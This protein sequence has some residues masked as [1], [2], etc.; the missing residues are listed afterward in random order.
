MSKR[1]SF[2]TAAAVVAL[3]ALAV[4]VRAEAPKKLNLKKG[5]RIVLMGNGL[6]S[7]MI[8]FGHFE[9]GLHLRHPELNLWIRNMC[10][11]GNTPS[12]RPH[13][14]RKYQLGFPGAEKFHAP[15]SDGNTADGVGHFETEEQWIARLKPDVLIAFFGFN[16]SFQGR[17]GIANFQAE[18]DAFLKHTKAQKYNGTSVAQLALVSPTAFEDLSETLDV[19][20]GKKQNGNLAAYTA[21]MK[22]V[23]ADNDVLFIDVFGPSLA[24][25][26]QSPKP[27]TADGALLNND[28]YE[29]FSEAL[30][31]GVFGPSPL[32]AE[33]HRK[34]VH[35]AVME[36]NWF[37]INDFKIPNGVH[38]FGRRYKP[39]G[40][41]NYPY[42]IKKIRE[43]TAHRDE[44][45]WA[46][47]EG[48][49]ID[50]A[51]RDKKTSPLPEVKTNFKP[52]KKNGALEYLKGEAAL[53][54][55][56]VPTGYKIQQFATEQE[57][58]NLQNPVQMSFD[59]KGR[60]WIAVM[61]SYPHYR[62]GDP[63]PDDKLLIY[64]DTNGDGKADKEIVF[65]D[66][67]HLPMG[68]ELAPEGVYVSQGINLVLLRDTDGDD[69]A[70]QKEVILSGFD[71]H[72]T[73]HAIG[74]YCA[75]PSGAF[76][77]CEGVFLRSNIETSR[78]PIRG[79]N[80]GFFRY[81]PQRKRLERHAQLS[82]PNPWGVAF[83]D[84]GQHFF[85]HTSGPT[86]EWM[87]PG[88]VKPRYGAANPKSR[89]LLERAHSVRPTSG[90]EFMSSRHFPDEVQGDL[91]LNNAIGFR[92]TKQHKMTEDGTGYKT[93]W[94]QDL[95]VSTDG[96]YR[97]VDLEIAPDGSLY[98]VDWHN[99]LI[100]H[101]QHNA[102]DPNRDHAHGRIYR[103][104]YP[105][106]PLVK[107]AKV[108]GATIAELL[109]NLKLHEYRTRYRTRRELRGRD[110]EKVLAAIKTWVGGLDKADPKYEHHLLE[111]LFVKWGLNRVDGSLLRTLLAAQDHRARAAAV[112]V[113][114]YNRHRI[115]D[116]VALLK[117][118]A[119]DPH[120][121][122]K[123]EAITAASWLP[124]NQ[125]L[126]VL[127]EAEKAVSAPKAEPAAE[128]ETVAR[129]AVKVSKGGGLI[130][131]A[132]PKLKN[133]KVTGF[134]ITVPGKN[135]T[136]NLMEMQIHA[137]GKN[138]T[139]QAQVSM[140]STYKGGQY[141]AK[142]L[143][144]GDESTM[145]HSA[146][147]TR[148]P[149]IT[150]KFAQ[151][152]A[153]DK[154]VIWN[155]KGYESRFHGARLEFLAG[156]KKLSRLTVEMP[157]GGSSGGGGKN[158]TPFDDWIAAS[159]KTALA[160]LNNQSIVEEHKV[161][162]PKHLAGDAAKLYTL[163][164]EIYSREAHCT[165]C[166]QA[167]GKGLAAA[168]F[169]PLDGSKWATGDEQRLIKL[170]L[171]G[172]HGPIT[173]KGK[174]YPGLVPMT[175]FKGLLTDEEIA[176]V[177]TYVRNS[178]GN[179]APMVKPE[180]VKQIRAATKGQAGFYAPADLL[181]T[182][183]FK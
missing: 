30:I 31:E 163:G 84:W 116:H 161:V 35:D 75:D 69:R 177:L 144:D 164:A 60:L 117:K 77:M 143:T 17:G 86:V 96:N 25:Y 87:L 131:V 66:K 95:T 129:G 10:D 146:D 128:A 90:I 85:L 101:M 61:P 149:K 154:I 170:T 130:E 7:R 42:E 93:E 111:A 107:P 158:N 179:K 166:H 11:E 140:N 125:G 97:P 78:G 41:A 71:D 36:K 134:T 59:N 122:V 52:S 167:D 176:A 148:N 68:F 74:A 127:A 81:S 99:P 1:F 62:P 83:D 79:T 103:I 181:K 120:G 98:I 109:D 169:P 48:Q 50:L 22:K 16:E 32:K 137:G 173:V 33:S 94:R 113:L 9:T 73:H 20:S 21:V 152:T 76:I 15:Y 157:G 34:R 119:A 102:R 6:G 63:M 13:S 106:R 57:F 171:H 112:R 183:P 121:R 108:H 70:D 65:A 88:T 105:A 14:G 175:P 56:Q 145:A 49:T 156:K 160:H 150:V 141:P 12:F 24:W 67:L 118:A 46:A 37:W 89:H 123:L 8:H 54:T 126:S 100:G 26:K 162:V 153:I 165:T 72:D 38:V 64:E 23:A 147:Q 104:T 44:A 172:L 18:L 135:R 92:G 19:P 51:A 159:Y 40:P 182:H 178:F 47:T 115:S 55:I 155:R 110:P 132:D 136:I 180:T 29:K 2:G 124:K 5:S 142:H 168:Q 82:I 43:M 151:P 53:K 28:G 58:P 39:F 45:I 114:R 133:A 27:L 80:G 3:A 4:S 91:M 138:I 139:D 174:K